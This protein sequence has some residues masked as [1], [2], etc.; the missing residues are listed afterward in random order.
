MPGRD[1]RVPWA[2]MP[3]PADATAAANAGMQWPAD[4]DG[5]S[6]LNPVEISGRLGNGWWAPRCVGPDM[7]NFDEI[8][9]STTGRR[10]L[11]S[12]DREVSAR[13]R[14]DG[15]PWLHASISRRL[16]MPDYL[17]LKLLHR[18]VFGD[19]AHAYQVFVPRAEHVNDHEFCLHLFGRLDGAPVLPDFT[20]GTGEI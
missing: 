20:H 7:W 19:G 18:A 5:R 6:Q 14:G 1:R 11:V 9:G 4:L 12:L 13:P 16:K 10:I 2:P 17:D 15:V 8:N 3:T